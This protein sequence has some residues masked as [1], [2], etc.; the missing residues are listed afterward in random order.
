MIRHPQRI[1][2]EVQKDWLSLPSTQRLLALEA[3]WLGE[4]MRQLY[5]RHILYAGVDEQPEFL[6]KSPSQH[7]FRFGLPWQRGLVEVQAEID[8]T[9][10]PL[11]DESIDVVVLQHAIDMTNRPHQLIREATR[12]MIS[13]GYLIV[14]GF[15]PWSWW[16]GVRWLRRLY[17]TQLPW[18]AN[19]VAPDRLIDWLTLLDFRVEHCSTAAHL[20]PMGVGSEKI[21]RHIDRVMAGSYLPGNLYV[22]VARK[23][24]AGMTSIRPQKR[25]SKSQ[26]LGGFAVPAAS[27]SITNTKLKHDS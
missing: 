2:V 16:G 25:V 26:S 6:S 19:P 3:G 10:W 12:S 9:D 17:S 11:P 22:L 18:V 5:G 20:W 21:S 7:C 4:W 27:T 8:D 15:N 13:G 1:K 24:V 14:V 23:T